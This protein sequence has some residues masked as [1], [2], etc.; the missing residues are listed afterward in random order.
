MERPKVKGVIKNSVR[1][2]FSQLLYDGDITMFACCIA[3]LVDHSVHSQGNFDLV[4][5]SIREEGNWY[6]EQK[7]RNRRKSK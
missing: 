7:K 1:K 4:M 3:R 5:Q 2:F 6:A